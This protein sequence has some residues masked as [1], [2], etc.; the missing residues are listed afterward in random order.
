MCGFVKTTKGL[1]LDISESMG[2]SIHNFPLILLNSTG[3]F[4][5]NFP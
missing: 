1:S 3:K 2:I 5:E 4:E